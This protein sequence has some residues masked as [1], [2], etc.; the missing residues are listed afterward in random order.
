MSVL[1]D[2]VNVDPAAVAVSDS[3]ASRTWAELD[4]R[5]H[6]IGRGLEAMGVSPGQHVALICSNRVDFVDLVVGITRGGFH[7]TP[8]KTN[9]AAP[10]MQALV[11][12]AG[13]VAVVADVPIGRD[14][15]RLAGLPLVDLSDGDAYDLWI[16]R[17]AGNP[18]P[19]G[20][21][22]VR[23][24]YTSG[25]TG[26][27]KGVHRT[28]PPPPFEDWVRACTTYNVALGM[29][30]HG[31][32][33]MVSQ[34]FHG[35][36]LNFGMGAMWAGCHLRILERWD[37]TT[38][39]DLLGGDTTASIMVPTMF[40]Q[41]LALPAEQRAAFDPSSLRAILHGGEA[42]PVQLKQDMIDWWGPIFTEYYGFTE[43]GMTLVD[44][45]DWSARPGTVGR[46]LGPIEISIRD[47]DGN[48]LPLRET[49]TVYFRRETG[50]YFEY[51]NAK[52]KTEAAHLADGSFTVGDLG[53]LD[54][55]GFLYLVGR[56][57]ELIVAAGVNIYPAEIEAAI[58]P[59]PGVTDACVVGGPDEKRGE[60]PVAFV[61]LAPGADAAT[62]EAAVAQRCEELLAGYKQPR[63]ISF[64]DEIPRDPT[65]KVLR[66]RLRATLW[67]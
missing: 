11:V 13:S 43:G 63:R 45:A 67:E 66:T 8:I 30:D 26:A 35:A 49:G 37:P 29:P 58:F 20:R 34:M 1:A 48:P 60:Q 32:H 46:P 17:H 19:P 5:S 16:D 42:C 10:E 52:E 9:W 39:L 18:L 56:T 65:G 64:I 24:P 36:P 12:D 47:D 44:N 28:A 53:W 31:T 3:T 15:A 40:R 25:T 50:R 54:E 21:R 6:A 57:A 4:R 41:L 61:Q 14:V 62:V 22:G 23:V 55:D 27:P 38:A 2:L 51:T 33:L 59:V 7:F